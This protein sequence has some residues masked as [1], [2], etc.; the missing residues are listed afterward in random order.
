MLT[1]HRRVLY[2]VGQVDFESVNFSQSVVKSDA[3][4]FK[5][6]DLLLGS[7][8]KIVRHSVTEER[9]GAAESVPMTFTAL[10]CKKIDP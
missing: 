2:A 6:P 1:D 3:V 9:G 4:I 10:T 5:L 8:V 7:F